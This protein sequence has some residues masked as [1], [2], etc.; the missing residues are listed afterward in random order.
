MMS[1]G[2]SRFNDFGM[3]ALRFIVGIIF[4]LHGLPKFANVTGLAAAMGNPSMTWFV[5]LLAAVE[6]LAGIAIIFGVYVHIPALIL[7]ITMF[8]AIYFKSTVWSISFIGQKSTG[9]EFDL[10]ILA[11]LI[12]IA[13]STSNH[14]I[15]LPRK[16]TEN[17]PVL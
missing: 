5:Y 11:A 15:F 2:L 14:F 3:F 6:I 17:K 4:V 8:G 1:K 7:S 10:L 16:K 13:T 9:W 12:A